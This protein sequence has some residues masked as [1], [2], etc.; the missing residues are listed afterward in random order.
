MPKDQEAAEGAVAPNS[1]KKIIII[2]VVALVLLLGGV[3]AWFMFA[4]GDDKDAAESKDAKTQEGGKDAA[5]APVA[6][7]VPLDPPFIVNFSSPGKRMRFLQLAMQV[8]TFKQPV[9][10]AV[11]LHMP[12]IRNSL[13]LII[14]SETLESLS[15]MEG[16][17]AL[18]VKIHEAINAIVKQ[19]TGEDGVESVYFTGFVMQ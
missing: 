18:R 8:S 15:S 1:K 6:M 10:D 2:V 11:N 9:A 14:G 5:P 17:E 19:H 16:K 13:V 3:G 4:G 12:A 7:Y